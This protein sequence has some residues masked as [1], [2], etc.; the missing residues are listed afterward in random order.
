MRIAP[1]K[2]LI[3]HTSQYAHD[4]KTV[5]CDLLGEAAD[6]RR[7]AWIRARI[8]VSKSGRHESLQSSVFEPNAGMADIWVP[9]R[10]GTDAAL[11]LAMLLLLT[12]ES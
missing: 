3:L 12:V 10:P 1:A 8:V 9:L 6:F 11:A 7:P 2:A 4:I 5:F